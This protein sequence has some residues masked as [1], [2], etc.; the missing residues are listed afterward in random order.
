MHIKVVMFDLDGTLLPMDLD[1]FMKAYFGGL[2][3]QMAKHG[4]DP[5]AFIQA[6]WTGVGAMVKNTGA[7][8]NEEVFLSVFQ[9]VYGEALPQVQQILD[10]YYETEFPKV[11]DYCGFDPAAAE[12]VQYLK[13]KDIDVVLATNPVFPAV[14]TKNRILWSGLMPTDFVWYT[15]YEN[16]SYCKPNP[17][18]YREILQRLNVKPEE[19]IMVGNDVTEDMVAQTLGMQVFL[20]TDCLINKE[21]KDISVYPH[22]NFCDLMHFLSTQLEN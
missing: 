13:K 11:K 7:H 6:I 4:Y 10:A 22:G 8:T 12:T 3:E 19:C 15:T 16:A 21:N 9:E 18:Y 1:V 20:L 17:D 5:K 14:A 2:S